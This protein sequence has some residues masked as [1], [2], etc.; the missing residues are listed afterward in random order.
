[1]SIPSK[2]D[3]RKTS[4]LHNIALFIFLVVSFSSCGVKAPPL[5][6]V[7]KEIIPVG[8]AKFLQKG[9]SLYVSFYLPE[10]YS[11]KSPLEIGKIKIH[12]DFYSEKKII[13]VKK[14]L[15]DAQEEEMEVEKGKRDYLF[16]KKLDKYSINLGLLIFYW[17]SKGKRSPPS[18]IFEFA[19]KPPPA[20]PKNLTADVLEKG[21]LLKWEAGEEKKDYGFYL[22]FSEGKEFKKINSEP[23]YKAEFL[24]SDFSWD[25]RY[26]FKVSA[27]EKNLYESEDSEEISLVPVDM[28]P[29][30]P[31][32]NI[33]AI[34]EEGFILLKWEKVDCEDLEKYNVYRKDNEKVLLLTQHG[35]KETFFEDKTGESGK[36]YVYFVTSVDKKGNE[37]KPSNM[38]EEKFR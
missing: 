16:T 10:T 36:I 26:T 6:P 20:K 34:P 1:M 5:P 12:F 38:V 21:I 35:T 27:V 3:K 32:Q 9:N 8:D 24:F 11:D 4:L 15:K 33:I 37:S 23:L 7:A 17:D 29:P 28:F 31:P 18:K 22:Y 25:V 30:P 2:I 13:N 19:I 14:F